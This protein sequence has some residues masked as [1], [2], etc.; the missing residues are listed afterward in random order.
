MHDFVQDVGLVAGRG[1]V[2]DRG[3]PSSRC[4]LLVRRYPGKP[5]AG[6]TIGPAPAEAPQLLLRHYRLTRQHS[7]PLT[8]TTN[9]LEHVTTELRGALPTAKSDLVLYQPHERSLGGGA[10][11]CD[12]IVLQQSD[13]C[14][15]V[16]KAPRSHDFEGHLPDP[17][18]IVIEAG[19]HRTLRRGIP[20]VQ[21]SAKGPRS[22]PMT[23]R[24]ALSARQHGARGRPGEHVSKV[25]THVTVVDYSHARAHDVAFAHSA[26]GGFDAGS[27]CHAPDTRHCFSLS[28]PP[29]P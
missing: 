7:S 23:R 21:E 12:V 2:G 8:F 10:H 17:P 16:S 29:S 6:G 15:G 11:S 24:T 26:E 13:C 28:E 22:W 27:R 20:G 1:Y 14:G 4:L 3:A 9:H 19:E 25:R 18:R 5:R